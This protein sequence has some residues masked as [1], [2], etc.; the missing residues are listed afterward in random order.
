MVGRKGRI[1]LRLFP[2]HKF[3]VFVSDKLP[4]ML[5]TAPFVLITVWDISVF[6]LKVQRYPAKDL[7]SSKLFIV[8]VN[9]ETSQ[10]RIGGDFCNYLAP[11]GVSHGQSS[12]FYLFA[13][14]LCCF[15]GGDW[16][17]FC[18]QTSVI[19]WYFCFC[20]SHLM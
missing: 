6:I 15:F 19:L 12:H 18:V 16:C 4:N 17:C 13:F 1:G 20:L 8:E 7:L 10:G 5:L 3:S 11:S 14:H 9:R 2:T